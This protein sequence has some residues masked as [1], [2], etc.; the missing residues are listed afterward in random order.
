[1]REHEGILSSGGKRGR[2]KKNISS[3]ETAV[4]ED[5]MVNGESEVTA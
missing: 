5:N 4:D 3:E 1:M 2:P